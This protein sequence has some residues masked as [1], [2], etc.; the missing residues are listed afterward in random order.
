MYKD[1]VDVQSASPS[2]MVV[3]IK[4]PCLWLTLSTFGVLTL[5]VGLQP[6][7]SRLKSCSMCS[8]RVSRLSYIPSFVAKTDLS[9]S[10]MFL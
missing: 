3:E 2:V 9:K 4:Y 7:G 1:F 8:F 6:E 5:T 10:Y